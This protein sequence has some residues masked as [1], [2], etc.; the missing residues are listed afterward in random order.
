[1]GQDRDVDGLAAGG[2][3]VPRGAL[4]RAAVAPLARIGGFPPRRRRR[5]PRR[6]RPR[7][8]PRRLSPQG[9][10]PRCPVQ[11]DRSMRRT[12]RFR[13]PT[14]EALPSRCRPP[15]HH[16]PPPARR[17]EESSGKPS[18]AP[19]PLAVSVAIGQPAVR[20]ILKANSCSAL[21]PEWSGRRF[22]AARPF[23]RRQQLARVT[24]RLAHLLRERDFPG[25]GPANPRDRG[26]S[27]GA[28]H[29]ATRSPERDQ[30]C[31]N[32]L[33]TRHSPTPRR[34]P[35]RTNRPS[36]NIGSR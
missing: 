5:V 23:A 33:R 27:R 17:R 34:R 9:P 35:N 30:D 16:N 18:T 7:S 13:P 32:Y 6:R 2:I 29:T 31:F 28:M 24:Q 25:R 4:A 19:P 10:S 8:P 3:D 11:S 21:E 1:L 12:I 14:P 26:R 36:R 20:T 22:T 15:S